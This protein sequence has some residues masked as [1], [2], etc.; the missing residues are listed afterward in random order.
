M[1]A[2]GRTRARLP[3]IR[4]YSRRRG[5]LPSSERM[6]DD[7]RRLQLAPRQGGVVNVYRVGGGAGA[8]GGG[9][10]TDPDAIHDNV[11]A[12]ISA[13]AEKVT[14]VAADKLVIEDSTAGNVKKM[15]QVGN[16]PG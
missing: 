7:L 16:L 15:V 4:Q 10:G 13:I 2:G 1:K 14:P 5:L 12:E 6:A 11:A 8:G 9:S 3:L